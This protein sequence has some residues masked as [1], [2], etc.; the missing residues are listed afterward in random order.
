MKADEHH[1]SCRPS[2]RDLVWLC[3]QCGAI[4]SAEPLVDALKR[5]RD[6]KFTSTN[7]YGYTGCSPDTERVIVKICADALAKITH[8]AKAKP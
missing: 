2:D 4:E 5:L 6:G 1:P 7:G 8:D 3:S